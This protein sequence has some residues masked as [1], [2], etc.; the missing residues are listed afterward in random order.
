[1]PHSFGTNGKIDTILGE[2][3]LST[4]SLSA[5]DVFTT[6]GSA[7]SPPAYW[8]DNFQVNVTNAIFLVFAG[9]IG[10]NVFAAGSCYDPNG[11][12]DTCE[13]YWINNVPTVLAKASVAIIASAKI[14]GNDFYVLGLKYVQYAQGSYYDSL[15]Y[16][17][18]GEINYVSDVSQ[19]IALGGISLAVW[20]P[21]VYVCT[22]VDSTFT[23]YHLVYWK[24]GVFNNL[25]DSFG[26]GAGGTNEIA[27]NGSGPY[28]VGSLNNQA[29]YWHNG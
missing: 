6:A 22:S 12:T 26:V 19:Y 2:P 1:M 3:F 21:D 17:K 29:A 23:P 11:G 24:N 5:T 25:P 15:V 7:N 4:I 13:C 27:V 28:I 18:N 8:K 20:G 16:W 9:T 14:I 10:N